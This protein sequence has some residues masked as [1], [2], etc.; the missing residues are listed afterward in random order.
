M[1]KGMKKFAALLLGTTMLVT[2]MAGC[3]S[4]TET[5][6]T[7]T[8]KTEEASTTKE[9]TSEATTASGEETELKIMLR[10]DKPDGWDTVE[11]A[12][13]DKM[14]ADGLNI[15]LNITWVA[16][17]DYKD[18]LNLAI[19]SGEDWDL[20]FDAPWAMLKT[21][22]A[23]EYYADLSSYWN[24]D[25]YPGL[26]KCFDNTLINNNVF[27]DQQCVIPILSAYGS[28][29]QTVHYRQDWADK[30]GIGKID[31]Y[32]KLVQYWDKCLENEG[33]SVYPLSV[34]GSRGF[35]Q[36]LS[37]Y[38][39]INE[40]G[41]QLF[42][43]GITYWTY[44]KDNKVQAIAAEG[45]GDEAFKDFPEPFNYDF[46]VKRF[47]TFAE[48]RNKGYI[49]TDSLNQSDEKTMFYNGLSASFIGTLDDYETVVKNLE[50]YSPDA[51]LGEFFYN[52]KVANKEEGAIATGFGA[53]NFLC[54]P[55]SSTKIEQAMQFINWIFVDEAN[56][57]LV[58]YG[59]EGTDWKD[60]GDGTYSKLS[61]YTFPAYLLTST[62][63][64]VKYADSLP[65]DIIEYK[66]YELKESTFV[67]LPVTGFTFDSSSIQ[68]E[69]AQTKAITDK[70]YTV[71]G[72]GILNDGTTTY[73][74]AKEML[75][76]NLDE[77]YKA[78]AQTIEDTLVQQLNDYLAAQSAT[79]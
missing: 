74:T 46:G 41:I 79:N 15:K 38:N 47:D 21:L 66:D 45:A 27:F 58:Q 36:L 70:I 73:A 62:R 72:H 7:E 30:W 17:A 68:T 69:F 10:S 1:K 19:T 6:T 24:N 4:K 23:D 51:V 16:P 28:G 18:K 31:S 76:A 49:E 5:S 54:I 34:T 39:G 78:G 37:N 75:K 11:T 26:K 12:V 59:I 71:K 55:K 33:G 64:Y 50:T 52:E 29:L 48:W 32:E 53:N 35:Y 40:A 56:H 43:N 9:S 2:S 13:E 25:K 67:K 14:A 77:A 22:A 60:N 65:A 3:Q 8:T 42:Q 57:D 61:T 44:I 63:E 20:V